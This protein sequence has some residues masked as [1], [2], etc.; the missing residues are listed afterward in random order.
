[1]LIG[2]LIGQMIA[3][4]SVNGLKIIHILMCHDCETQKQL[5]VMYL[6]DVF[7]MDQQK[8]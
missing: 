1:M 4:I 5:W 7:L 6:S 8:M 2:P 3:L